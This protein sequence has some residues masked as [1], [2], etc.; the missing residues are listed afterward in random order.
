ML[1]DQSILYSL[2]SFIIL[3]VFVKLIVPAAVDMLSS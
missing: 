2:F 3:A 1:D